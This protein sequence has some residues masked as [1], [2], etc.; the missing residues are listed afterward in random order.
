MAVSILLSRGVDMKSF[1]WAYSHDQKLKNSELSRLLQHVGQ[2]HIN[3][4]FWEGLHNAH[5]RYRLLSLRAI[6]VL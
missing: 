3:C 1:I 4:N 2:R 5:F 6:I